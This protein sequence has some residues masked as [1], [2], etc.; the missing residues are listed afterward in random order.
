MTSLNDD[1]DK[2]QPLIDKDVNTVTSSQLSDDE[3]PNIIAFNPYQRG[4]SAAD[5]SKRAKSKN[6]A[7]MRKTLAKS[8]RS[9]EL[10]FKSQRMNSWNSNRIPEEN[11]IMIE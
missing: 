2:E 3:K 8:T 9:P 1:D 6:K 4:N 5:S 10:S 7:S 11:H